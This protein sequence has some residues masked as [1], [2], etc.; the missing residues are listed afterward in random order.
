MW[1]VL[2]K[3]DKD[4]LIDI[5]KSSNVEPKWY[6][7]S[8]NLAIALATYFE[9]HMD[10]PDD[11]HIHDDLGWSEWVMT[12]TNEAIE[13]IAEHIIKELEK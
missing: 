2:N 5:L 12:K 11:D 9:N 6:P 10:R 8:D 13:N 3:M 7:M 1:K 4:K